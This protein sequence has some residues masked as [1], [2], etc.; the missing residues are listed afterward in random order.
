MCHNVFSRHYVGGDRNIFWISRKADTDICGRTGYRIH[1]KIYV[2]GYFR[3]LYFCRTD[4]C[5]NLLFTGHCADK[6][7]PFYNCTASG[8][9]ACSAGFAVSF[10]RFKCRVVD[11][12]GYGADC[13][14]D[15]S[16]YNIYF[17]QTRQHDTINSSGAV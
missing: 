12:S 2:S 7:K 17:T 16:G 15:G 14:T 3:Q 8:I 4:D 10:Y 6:D 9:F 11:I 13:W 5:Y 1:W